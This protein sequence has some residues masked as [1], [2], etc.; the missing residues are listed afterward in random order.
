MNVE[1]RTTN[2]ANDARSV[3]AG[4]DVTVALDPEG[5]AIL[6]NFLRAHFLRALTGQGRGD[7]RPEYRET[8]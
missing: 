5:S 2:T 1:R 8:P 7:P 3:Q 6:G 4:C